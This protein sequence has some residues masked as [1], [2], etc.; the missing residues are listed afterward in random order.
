M[1]P[2]TTDSLFPTSMLQ[3]TLHGPLGH[4]TEPW[5]GTPIASKFLGNT[6]AY[7]CVHCCEAEK[8]VLHANEHRRSRM[9][10]TL[11]C[12][13]FSRAAKKQSCAVRVRA[14][15]LHTERLIVE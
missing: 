14:T 10:G 15:S 13:W 5:P 9:D 11:C 6:H 7:K 12:Q 1:L 4:M 2:N 8:N 3:C